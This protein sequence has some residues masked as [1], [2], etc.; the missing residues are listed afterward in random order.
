MKCTCG[1]DHSEAF[2]STYQNR[3]CCPLCGAVQNE[4]GPIGGF[5]WSP[6]RRIASVQRLLLAVERPG[7]A[8]RRAARTRRASIVAAL[9][10]VLGMMACLGCLDKGDAARLTVGPIAMI[11]MT[12]GA[13]GL[14]TPLRGL[15]SQSLP[16]AGLLA[17]VL[18]AA[19]ACLPFE[20][21][22]SRTAESRFGSRVDRDF[23]P[24][25]QLVSTA[26]PARVADESTWTT[27]PLPARR[28]MMQVQVLS[29]QISRGSANEAFAADASSPLLFVLLEVSNTSDTRVYRY[30]KDWSLMNLKLKDNFG[31]FYTLYRQPAGQAASGTEVPPALYPGKS[32]RTRFVFEPPVPRAR[33]LFMELPAECMGGSDA[34]RIRIPIR[35]IHEEAR[36]PDPQHLRSR[37]QSAP[38]GPARV[39]I[40]TAG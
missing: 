33:D 9:G 15:R 8:P 21:W 34:V 39:A 13:L 35:L 7:S 14:R 30:Y 6:S 24:E 5:T 26:F 37:T 16:L 40:H 25:S 3:F 18:A 20:K 10:M 12:L 32:Y 1:W 22:N 11:A 4:S 36:N 19:L 31:N 27:A 38:E 17:A 29:A 2:A 23:E 28:S